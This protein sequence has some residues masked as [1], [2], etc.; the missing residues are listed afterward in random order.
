[1]YWIEFAVGLGIGI[2]LGAGILTLLAI[3]YGGRE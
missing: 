1:M 2:L 3:T